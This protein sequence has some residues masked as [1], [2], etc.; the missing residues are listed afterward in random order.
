MGP[1]AEET[2]ISVGISNDLCDEEDEATESEMMIIS[3][4]SKVKKKSAIEEDE[5][6]FWTITI[7]VFF[8]FLIAGLGMVGAGLVLDIVQ[9][10]SEFHQ[11]KNKVK[12]AT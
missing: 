8:P 5:E 10:G 12:I 7:Q 4:G 11:V 6:T 9:V 2:D 1:Q 3:R